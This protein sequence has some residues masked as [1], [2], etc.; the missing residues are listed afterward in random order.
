MSTPL[1]S[2]GEYYKALGRWRQPYHADY[3]AQ[4]SSQVGGIVTDPAL[5]NVPAD[6]HMVHRGD[7]VFEV[8]KCVDGRAY[9]LGDHL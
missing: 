5:W 2:L 8:F 9:C 4:Y 1:L 3:L 6:D 7:A